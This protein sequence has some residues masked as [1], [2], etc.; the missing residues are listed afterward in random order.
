MKFIKGPDFPTAASPWASE[1]IRDAYKTGRGSIKVRAVT[2]VEEGAPAADP[3]S[4]CRS[5]R[6]R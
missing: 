4:S 2:T 1:G 5:F 6:T 3:G